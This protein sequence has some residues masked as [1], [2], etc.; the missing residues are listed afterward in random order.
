[1]SF[2]L[3]P[4]T[5][6]LLCFLREAVQTQH[7]SHPVSAHAAHL[8]RRGVFALLVLVPEEL[9]EAVVEDGLA[10]VV[11]RRRLSVGGEGDERR[12]GVALVLYLPRQNAA[13]VTS[14]SATS[15]SESLRFSTWLHGPTVHS[16]GSD[17][18][19][20]GELIWLN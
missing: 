7:V 5:K 15:V 2:A 13:V 18:L 19:G 16:T 9:D 3:L 17:E 12:A 4:E 10:A 11:R 6:P 14:A 1:M 8:R 20:G